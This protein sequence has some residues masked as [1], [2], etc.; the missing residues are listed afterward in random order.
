[1]N[2]APKVTKLIGLTFLTML[3]VATM[4]DQQVILVPAFDNM[5]IYASDDDT[6]QYTVYSQTNNGIG[7]NRFYL[8]Y[9][10]HFR[11]YASL[12]YF[13]L[14]ALTGKTIVSAFLQLYPVELAGDPYQASQNTD[15][16]V[17]VIA[18]PWNPATVTY[19]NKP[20]YYTGYYQLFD[21][22]RGIYPKIID[23]TLPVQYWSDGTIPNY[24]FYS[25]DAYNSGTVC[26]CMYATFFGS[27]ESGDST[28]TP[29]LVVTFKEGG[30]L[31]P[32]IIGPLLLD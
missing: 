12:I 7:N 16:E 1:M 11:H 24:G 28:Q 10:Y 8:G 23:V 6:M 29:R 19:D 9:D 18:D 15:Y 5:V 22:P 4:A 14:S 31:V 32:A 20:Q 27:K 17:R 21:V 3:P 13:D 25:T 2:F 30:A 26:Q